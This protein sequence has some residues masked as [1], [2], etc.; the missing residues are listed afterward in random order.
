M[1]KLGRR[2]IDFLNRVE[3]NHEMS[4]LD[5]PRKIIKKQRSPLL[6]FCLIPKV[7]F[8]RFN[9]TFKATLT[10]L[11]MVYYSSNEAGTCENIS[12][13]TMAKRL[14]TS[15][16]TI[17]RGIEELERKGAL[18]V[19]KRSKKSLKGDR[20]PLPSLYELVDLQEGPDEPI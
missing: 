2:K 9:P 3:L 11:A 17:H 13:S 5:Q 20:V 7:F 18:I 4:D 12:L 15:K 10:Y 14:N 19:H 8:T 16:T 6:P 1:I